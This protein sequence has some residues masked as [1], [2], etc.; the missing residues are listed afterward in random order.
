MAISIKNDQ[1]EQLARKVAEL[2]GESITEAIRSSLAERFERLNRARRG[3]TLADEINE[4]AD[5]C[6]SRPRI[7]NLTDDEI[8]GYDEFGAPTR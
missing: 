6:A 1:A 5:R 2:T 7:S 3:R 4:I 8:L